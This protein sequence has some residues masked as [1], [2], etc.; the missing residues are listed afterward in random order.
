MSSRRAYA[1]GW[2]LSSSVSAGTSQRVGW[3]GGPLGGPPELSARQPQ[4]VK[5][6][7]D[8][9]IEVV[10]SMDVGGVSGPLDHRLMS[11]GD[12]GRHVLGGRSEGLVLLA[13]DDE[14][15]HADAG[16]AVD[17]ARIELGQHAP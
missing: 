7:Q 3:R 17:D 5:E 11:A 8:G 4:A 2:A 6:V 15:R 1:Q 10:R 13:D 9:C 14:R 12:A 16:H